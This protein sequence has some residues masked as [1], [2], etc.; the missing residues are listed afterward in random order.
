MATHVKRTRKFGPPLYN[1]CCGFRSFFFFFSKCRVDLPL[2]SA[3]RISAVSV[4]V[5][6]WCGKICNLTE[7]Q[8]GMIVGA[9]LVGVSAATV[10]NVVAVSK[11][12]MPNVMRTYSTHGQTMSVKQNNFTAPPAYHDTRS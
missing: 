7:S 8:R 5:C 10:A 6:R 3:V 12:T 11:G 2:H 9:H 4:V 1:T